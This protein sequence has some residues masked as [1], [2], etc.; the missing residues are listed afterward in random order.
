MNRPPPEDS[1]LAAL[2]DEIDGIDDAIH[3]LIMRRMVLAN[4]ISET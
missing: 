1:P 4:R 3:D 2:R